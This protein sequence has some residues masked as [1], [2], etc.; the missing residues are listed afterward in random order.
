[1]KRPLVKSTVGLA[2]GGGG[3]RGYAHIGVLSV[4]KQH[5]IPI[6]C[7]AGTSMGA[8][9]GGAF[10][11]GLDMEQL[12][13]MIKELDLKEMLDIP[14]GLTGTLRQLL[15][16]AA[17]EYLFRREW[18]T[19][20]SESQAHARTM[21]E[22]FAQFTGDTRFE[23]LP[24]PFAAVATDIDTGEPI[25]IREGLICQAIEASATVPIAYYPVELGGRYLV[26]GGVVD[27]VP[28]DAAIAMGADRVIAVDVGTMPLHEPHSTLEIVTRIDLI[29]RRQLARAQEAL[30]QE[31]LGEE[32]LVMLRPDVQEIDWTAFDCVDDCIRAGEQEALQRLEEI[33]RLTQ[34]AGPMAR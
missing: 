10:V 12:A 30:A 34:S 16:R 19:L 3:A 29:A 26:D 7:V 24:T 33:K 15:G 21:C 13:E 31:R 28:I 22:L 27:L 2:L 6:D 18:R 23:D 11:C 1:M 25:F 8:A 9:I 17:S 14:E 4:L 20:P 32:H 5:E